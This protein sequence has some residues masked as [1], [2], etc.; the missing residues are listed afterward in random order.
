MKKSVGRIV[1]GATLALVVTGL[2]GGVADAAPLI[3][4]PADNSG[5]PIWLLPGVDLGPILDATIGL[6]Q[7]AL[8][9]V[10]GLLTFLNG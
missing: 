7:S 6:P 5:V 3:V 1:A 2:A 9:P 4:Q 10:S 8:A